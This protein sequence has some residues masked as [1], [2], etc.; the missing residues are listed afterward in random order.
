MTTFPD[1]VLF[2]AEIVII[3]VWA[4]PV[5]PKLNVFLEATLEGKEEAVEENTPLVALVILI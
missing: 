2:L 4:S 5:L 3:L 1:L